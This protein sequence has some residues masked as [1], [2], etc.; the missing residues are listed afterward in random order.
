MWLGR[1]TCEGSDSKEPEDKDDGSE[2]VDVFQGEAFD[3]SC[4]ISLS[5][6]SQGTLLMCF[7]RKTHLC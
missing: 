4:T 7:L 5:I 3:I 2:T 6:L 1:M